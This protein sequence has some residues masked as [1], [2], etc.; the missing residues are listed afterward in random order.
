MGYLVYGMVHGIVYGSAAVLG[1]C[2]LKCRGRGNML[3]RV[4]HQ[5]QGASS[6]GQAQNTR[7]LAQLCVT[8]QEVLVAAEARHPDQEAREYLSP[9]ICM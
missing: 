2:G 3:R 9:F 7:M 1:T 5:V 4:L 6:P 8:H